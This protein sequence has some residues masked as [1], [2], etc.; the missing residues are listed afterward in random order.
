MSAK[1]T[2]PSISPERSALP[3]SVPGATMTSATPARVLGL[4]QVGTLRPRLDADLVVLDQDLQ[5]TAVM[6]NGEWVLGG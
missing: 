6:A 1:V 4:D 2:A 3:P 5:L